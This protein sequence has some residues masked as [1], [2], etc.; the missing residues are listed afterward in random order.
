MLSAVKSFAAGGPALGTEAPMVPRTRIK[1]FEGIV[2]KSES[3]K[4]LGV[5]PEEIAT[6]RDALPG[7]AAERAGEMA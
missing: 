1:S 3:W 6:Y 2:P 7:S 5:T 4:T